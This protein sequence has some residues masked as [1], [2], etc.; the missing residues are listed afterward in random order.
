MENVDR[1]QHSATGKPNRAE[2]NVKGQQQ[3]Q[4]GQN[5]YNSVTEQNR[6]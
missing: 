6:T 2:G 1:T 5:A 4:R 3:K